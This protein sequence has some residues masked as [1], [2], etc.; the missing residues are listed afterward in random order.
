MLPQLSLSLDTLDPVKPVASGLTC[1][2]WKWGGGEQG[3]GGSVYS[4]VNSREE[5]IGVCLVFVV[6]VVCLVFVCLSFSLKIYLFTYLRDAH[7][8]QKKM[9][10]PPELG[11]QRVMSCQVVLLATQFS[12]QP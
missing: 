1:G 11:L 12:L 9:S 6:G 5:Q 2:G 8:G 10:D 4:Q 3:W 7:G